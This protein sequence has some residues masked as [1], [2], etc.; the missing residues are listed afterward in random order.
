MTTV[1]GGWTSER[2]AAVYTWIVQPGCAAWRLLK[3]APPLPTMNLRKA[4]SH[5]TITEEVLASD[6]ATEEEEEEEEEEGGPLS[7]P[8]PPTPPT[9]LRP[10]LPAALRDTPLP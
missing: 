4:G 1:P 10:P 3:F 8:T 7:S 5:L 6:T 2:V 9:R